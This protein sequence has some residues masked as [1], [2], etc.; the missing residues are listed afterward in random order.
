MDFGLA[1][2]AEATSAY[3]AGFL[4]DRIHLSVSEVSLVLALMGT[5]LSIVWLLYYLAGKGAAAAPSTGTLQCANSG[6]TTPL[7]SRN[8]TNS[9]DGR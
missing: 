8:K 7:V 3:L 5:V 2:L 4:Q 6:E 9:K 1:L